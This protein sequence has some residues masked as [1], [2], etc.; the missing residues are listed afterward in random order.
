MQRI[1]SRPLPPGPPLRRSVRTSA[2][3]R[4]RPIRPPYY[5][6]LSRLDIERKQVA[7][8]KN[9]TR[10]DEEVGQV[11]VMTW[12]TILCFLPGFVRFH[13]VPVY[14]RYIA[15]RFQKYIRLKYLYPLQK[16]VARWDSRFDAFLHKL[17]T[18]ESNFALGMTMMRLHGR[19]G[20]GKD[21]M[22]RFGL[23]IGKP[24]DSWKK[25]ISDDEEE[26]VEKEVEAEKKEEE[27][28]EDKKEDEEEDKED[29]TDFMATTS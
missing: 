4:P 29:G 23:I 2:W 5:D 8:W 19:I 3:L 11:Q 9:L 12:K 28:V 26:E 13:V 14:F 27:E 18:K 17:S 15:F 24:L 7:E 10:T 20:P 21:L 6:L 1:L 16:K 25:L 22:Y